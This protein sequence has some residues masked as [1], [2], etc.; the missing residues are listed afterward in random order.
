MK[1]RESLPTG[2]GRGEDFDIGDILRVG[3]LVDLIA[4]LQD[5]QDSIIIVITSD[6]NSARLSTLDDMS[7]AELLGCLSLAQDAL[8]EEVL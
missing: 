2:P 6:G 7:R 3:S 5:S 4:V 8:N 1:A